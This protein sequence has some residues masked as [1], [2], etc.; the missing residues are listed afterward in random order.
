MGTISGM[1]HLYLVFQL[2][3]IFII[4]DDLSRLYGSMTQGLTIAVMAFILWTLTNISLITT[5]TGSPSHWSCPAAPPPSQCSK[6]WAAG[7]REPS[8][9]QHS[10]CGWPPLSWSPWCLACQAT[11]KKVA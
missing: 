5:S 11:R 2:I 8:H 6:P 10:L 4:H 7:G 9:R 1:G 3:G